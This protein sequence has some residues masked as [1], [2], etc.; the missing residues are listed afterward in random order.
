M[1]SLGA[2]AQGQPLDG[3]L[4]QAEHRRDETDVTVSGEGL[5]PEGAPLPTCD[6][7]MT[8]PRLRSS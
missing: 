6:R 1:D 5:G 2:D 7:E 3:P 4:D 8:S